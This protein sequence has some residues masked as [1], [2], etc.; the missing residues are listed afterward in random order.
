MCYARM[1]TGVKQERIQ[2]RKICSQRG[3]DGGGNSGN[4]HD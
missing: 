4:N 2:S 1:E 3:G